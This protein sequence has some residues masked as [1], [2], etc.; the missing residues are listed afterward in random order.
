MTAPGWYPDPQ[1]GP[2]R[3]YWDGTRWTEHTDQGAAG[4]PQQPQQAAQPQ[5]PQQPQQG[6]Y[7]GQ[8]QPQ[9]GAYPGQQQAAYGQ[10]VPGGYGQQGPYGQ[11][12]PGQQPQAKPKGNG[13]LWIALGVAVVLILAIG[14]W[15]LFFRPSNNVAVPPV[16]T[17]ATTQATTEETTTP[18]ETTTAPSDTPTGQASTPTAGIPNPGDALQPLTDCPGSAADA[19]G[20]LGADGRITAASGMSM[21][22]VSGFTPGPLQF[23][24]IHG[25]NSQY[26]QYTDTNWVAAMQVGSLEASESFTD[27][28]TA[29]VRLAQ[30][31]LGNADY[32]Y[33]S[34]TVVAYDSNPADKVTYVDVDFDVPGGGP[35]TK[36]RMTFGTFEIGG[37]LHVIVTMVPDNDPT[38]YDAVQ[39]ALND[40]SVQ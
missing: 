21:P 40:L 13:P 37:K 1:G 25:S 5:Q 3:R 10:Q 30:C 31:F 14:S 32:G 34:A 22:Q 4:A 19:K 6:A 12:V 7:P 33:P 18:V 39:K 27:H 17:P 20:E 26:K 29:G 28:A 16:T 24:W 23:P 36:D 11:G 2:G 38:T 8:Q 15:L 9:Q 35:I